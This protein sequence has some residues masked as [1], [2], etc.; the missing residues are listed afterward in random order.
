[1]HGSGP[2]V[3]TYRQDNTHACHI[4]TPLPATEAAWGHSKHRGVVCWLSAMSSM[5]SSPP[6]L[7]LTFGESGTADRPRKEL[8]AYI[9]KAWY[10]AWAKGTT[11][12]CG[13]TAVSTLVLFLRSTNQK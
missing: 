3:S 7:E 12:H 4:A 1:M 9:R 8:H 2:G 10:A 13:F 6:E 11:Q 5:G